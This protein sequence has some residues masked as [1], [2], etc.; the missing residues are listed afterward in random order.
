[1]SRIGYNGRW[2]KTTRAWRYS[3]NY[4]DPK[5]INR[6]VKP[7]L[8]VALLNIMPTCP[9]MPTVWRCVLP[10]ITSSTD[11]RNLAATCRSL[12]QLVESELGWTALICRKFGFRLWLRHVRQMSHQ[13][14][15]RSID[16]HADIETMEKTEVLNECATIPRTFLLNT[17][18][19]QILPV[20]RVILRCY[21]YHLKTQV[22]Q[23]IIYVAPSE[24]SFRQFASFEN[25]H[26]E[27]LSETQRRT[28]P[29]TKLIY[30]YLADRRQLPALDFSM[31]YSCQ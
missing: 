16:L 1:M 21:R 9:T 18:G 12:Y 5:V 11:L 19:H 14:I 28:V 22:S 6:W 30:F 3:C 31:I 4:E 20:T 13:R 26:S 10:H 8:P 27:H 7:S 29:L 17:I 15:H 25:I 24:N 2:R 23:D